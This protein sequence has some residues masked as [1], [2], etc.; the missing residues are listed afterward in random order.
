MADKDLHVRL[1]AEEMKKLERYCKRTK[2]TK[3]DVIRELVR[4]LPNSG[5][6]RK[7]QASPTSPVVGLE[8]SMYPDA[9]LS[10]T[11]RDL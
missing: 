7:A 8:G 9:D 1:S 10:D 2:R 11:A 4:W 6:K 5:T 3:T